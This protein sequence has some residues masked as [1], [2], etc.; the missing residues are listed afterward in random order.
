MSKA[1]LRQWTSDNGQWAMDNGQWTMDNG[2]W[3]MDNGQWTMD[4]ETTEYAE[5]TP[6]L[7]AAI[8]PACF[9]RVWIVACQATKP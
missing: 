9:F 7:T 6:N 1:S 3:T 5:L 4:N 8:T 2:Q